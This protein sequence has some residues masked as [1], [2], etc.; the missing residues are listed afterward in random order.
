V[1]LHGD[2]LLH[3]VAFDGFPAG[4]HEI[5][6]DLP[7]FESPVRVSCRPRS[8]KGRLLS[9]VSHTLHEADDDRIVDGSVIGWLDEG[10]LDLGFLSPGEYRLEIW[11]G[12]YRAG[13]RRTFRVGEGPF[14]DLGEI[15]LAPVPRLRG[16]V[17]DE[18]GRPCPGAWVQI[19]APDLLGAMP[20]TWTGADGSFELPVFRDGSLCIRAGDERDD[21]RTGWLEVGPD[22]EETFHVVRLER[23]G[24][25]HARLATPVRLRES[26][27][28]T[29][30]DAAGTEWTYGKPEF[31]GDGRLVGVRIGDQEPGTF[32]IHVEGHTLADEPWSAEGIAIVRPGETTEILLR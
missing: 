6:V 31:D 4:T 30:I 9:E 32:R 13:A 2:A 16:R 18:A 8:P 27:R 20:E 10:R 14:L 15:P 17:V 29:I 24:G 5:V 26:P 22:P 3:E 28:T 7:P 25:I 19:Y 21:L 23:P 12:T 11:S 1:E